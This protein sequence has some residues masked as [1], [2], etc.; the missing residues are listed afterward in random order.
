MSLT[1]RRKYSDFRRGYYHYQELYT[2]SKAS[3]Q[4]RRSYSIYQ[5]IRVLKNPREP[6]SLRRIAEE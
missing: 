4:E 1:K 5:D 2:P 6:K 3:H